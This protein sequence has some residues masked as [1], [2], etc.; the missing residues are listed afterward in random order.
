MPR[1][2]RVESTGLSPTPACGPL[3]SRLFVVNPAD[4]GHLASIT[5]SGTP[6][7][8]SLPLAQSNRAW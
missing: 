6:A 7:H 2:V 5:G 4:G 3:P 8:P 1:N